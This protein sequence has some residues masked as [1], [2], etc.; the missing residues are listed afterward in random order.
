[1]YSNSISLS[2]IYR[3]TTNQPVVKAKLHLLGIASAVVPTI[4]YGSAA[5]LVTSSIPIAVLAGLVS[6]VKYAYDRLQGNV[7]SEY[8]S[9]NL[10]F[11]DTP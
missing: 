7:H 6:P 2:N 10:T 1:M 8:T 4:V 3:V 11:E 9:V 5:L